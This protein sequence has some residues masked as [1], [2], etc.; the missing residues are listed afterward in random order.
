MVGRSAWGR[1]G[2]A[3]ARYERIVSKQS[4]V[5]MAAPTASLLGRTAERRLRQTSSAEATATRAEEP[6]AVLMARAGRFIPRHNA[7]SDVLAGRKAKLP[8]LGNRD[9]A[10]RQDHARDRTHPL[11]GSNPK[12]TKITRWVACEAGFRCLSREVEIPHHACGER[13]SH[14]LHDDRWS[15]DGGLST[16]RATL[17]QV[18]VR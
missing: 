6:N 12:I 13:R 8:S 14:L 9:V 4:I 1:R 15:E 7:G 16:R 18:V 11:G 17:N 3:G 10:T 2:D 5:E